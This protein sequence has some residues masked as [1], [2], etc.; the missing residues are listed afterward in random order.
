[1][2][3]LK[4]E[5]AEIHY[6]GYGEGYLTGDPGGGRGRLWRALVLTSLHC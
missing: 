6:E 5:D 2:A 1:M 4:L 3:V